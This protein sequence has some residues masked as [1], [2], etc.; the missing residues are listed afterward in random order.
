[1]AR[2]SHWEQ[3]KTVNHYATNIIRQI[4]SPVLHEYFV[5]HVKLL[6]NGSDLLVNTIQALSYCGSGLMIYVICSKFR[7]ERRYC[8]LASFIWFL[9]P[10]CLAESVTT[11]ADHLAAL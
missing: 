7:L 9:T 6:S 10:I 3:N 2:V 8:Y 4:T 5:F 11:Q 1:M